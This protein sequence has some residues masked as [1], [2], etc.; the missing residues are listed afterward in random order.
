[1]EKYIRKMNEKERDTF[2]SLLYRN[3]ADD[4]GH[5]IHNFISANLSLSPIDKLAEIFRR[6]DL[7]LAEDY[8]LV[9]ACYKY[10]YI[11]TTG[12]A[13]KAGIKPI[14]MTCEVLEAQNC[15]IGKY[16]HDLYMKEENHH[17]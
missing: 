5:F 10:G 16:L 12:K 15:R 9:A 11:C 4:Y 14:K 2:I 17:D 7:F 13:Q 6:N 3:A 1:M 8:T